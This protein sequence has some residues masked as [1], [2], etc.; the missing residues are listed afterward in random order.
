VVKSE[1]IQVFDSQ[2]EAYKRAFQIFLDHTDQKRNAKRFLQKL[3]DGLPNRNVFIDAGAGNGEVTKAFA[4]AFDRTIAI[5]PNPHLLTQLKQAIPQAETIGAPI[6]AADPKVQGDFVLCSHTLYYIPAEEWLAHL[7]RLVSWMSPTGVTVVVVQNRDTACMAM[8]DHFLGHRFDLQQLAQAF[9][10]KHGD[11]YD[12]LITLD[13]AHV[14]TR[15]PASAYAIAEFMLNLLPISQPPAHHEVEDYLAKHC[16]T[17][18]TY[19]LSVHQ[20][21]LQIRSR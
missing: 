17:N 8:L 11:Q 19:R 18:G 3:V 10:E 2:G 5:E 21:F 1:L 6:L 7:D 13:P 9:R 15:E 16:V 14:E 12:A 4:G 20:D